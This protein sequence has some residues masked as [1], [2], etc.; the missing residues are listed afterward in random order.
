[1]IDALSPGT[2]APQAQPRR[3]MRI[4]TT[5]VAT[6]RHERVGTFGLAVALLIIVVS[7]AASVLPLPDPQ[8]PQ[9]LE[10]MQG[11][12]SV[13]ADGTMHLAGTDQLGRDVLSRTI[14]GARVSLGVA[15]ATV[16]IS[17]TVGTLLGLVSGARG[18]KLDYVI[19][20]LVDFQMAMP[21][22]LLAIFLLYLIGTSIAN[23]ILLLSIMSWYS[24]ARVVRS[25]V[26]RLR[27]AP[28]VEAAQV[29]GASSQRIML[30]HL[31]P[32]VVPL[33]IV[34]AIFDFSTVILAEA[35][36]SFLGLGVQPPD[37]S[38]GRMISEGQQYITTG[39]WWL[40]AAPGLAIFITVLSARLGSSWFTRFF[41]GSRSRTL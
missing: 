40:F 5:I 27:S 29:C 41:E 16:M 8:A 11:P 34:I 38:W 7:V 22:L 24:Y 9:L 32:Q 2:V 14:V 30:R 23:L 39:A 15:F 3:W 26:L 12:L 19:M 17:G 35:G 10:R 28:F 33:L 18:G 6:S 21:S 31:L 20:R 37:T 1:M 4:W 36:I 25:E 13:G